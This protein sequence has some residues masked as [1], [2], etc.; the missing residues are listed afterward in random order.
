MPQEW[1]KVPAAQSCAEGPTGCVV[2]GEPK[3][4]GVGVLG[5]HSLPKR[6]V[7]Q[8]MPLVPALAVHGQEQV[9]AGEGLCGLSLSAVAHLLK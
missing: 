6:G 4:R 3:L 1:G 2:S 9:A 8:E 7:Q 5:S